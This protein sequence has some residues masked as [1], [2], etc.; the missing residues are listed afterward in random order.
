[1]RRRLD[2]TAIVRLVLDR[3][4]LGGAVLDVDVLDRA[5]ARRHQG[6][7]I[8][9]LYFAGD[10]AAAE[11][12]TIGSSRI[13]WHP[14]PYSRASIEAEYPRLL[15]RLR[16]AFV[17]IALAARPAVFVNHVPENQSGAFLSHV[18]RSFDVPVCAVFHG[19]NRP[20]VTVDDAHARAIDAVTANLRASAGLADIVGAVSASAAAMMPLTRVRN[21]WTGADSSFFDP[22]RVEP[23]HL[24]HRFAFPPPLPVFLLSGRMVPEKGH[25]VLLDASSILHA[26]EIDHRIVF[27]GSASPDVRYALD[28][29]LA[30]NGYSHVRTIYDA[31]QEEMVDIYRDADVVVLPSFH[32]EGCPRCLIEAGLMGKPVVA[33]DSGGT[34]EAFL[35]GE[36]GILVPVGDARALADA[37]ASLATDRALRETMGRAGREFAKTRFDLDALASRHEEA[38]A[39]LMEGRRG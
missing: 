33:T 15:E 18:A 24:R 22:G 21:F 25:R 7:E 34:R 31:T 3:R 2:K 29:Y 12:Q 13:H 16:C 28:G 36:T 26:R 19:G 5:L 17:D 27:A 23:G 38:Y 20:A 9:K 14:I 10:D 30:T 4:E 6:L 39:A 8:H 32:F 35:P 37:L 1:M 11:S